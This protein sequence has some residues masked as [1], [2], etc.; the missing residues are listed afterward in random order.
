[1]ISRRCRAST[2]SSASRV[3][4]SCC[5][6][7]TTSGSAQSP[8]NRNRSQARANAYSWRAKVV[9][10]VAKKGSRNGSSSARWLGHWM[11]R[12]AARVSWNEPYPAPLMRSQASALTVASGRATSAVSRAR[13]PRS[14]R[15]RA[16]SRAT[17]SAASG[18]PAALAVMATLQRRSWSTGTP[19]GARSTRSTSRSRAGVP[20]ASDA[21]AAAARSQVRAMSGA[22][23][24]STTSMAR[25][26]NACGLRAA[27]G[28]GDV[29]RQ[30]S[31]GALE[32]GVGD[33]EVRLGG[34]HPGDRLEEVEGRQPA[35][36]DHVPE[37]APQQLP[38]A[39]VRHVAGGP[40]RERRRPLVEQ[41]AGVVEVTH[42]GEHERRH[43][44]AVRIGHGRARALR[45]DREGGHAQVRRHA[46]QEAQAHRVGA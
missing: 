21:A 46:L 13:T 29:V 16:A 28:L 11:P 45:E 9:R 24:R 38:Q 12:M 5:A 18:Y 4:S 8:G 15:S 19:S 43:R 23:A 6:R 39:R 42:V 33:L 35:L 25:S 36:A 37:R 14:D 40:Q 17:R 3:A 34:Q 22:G 27:L 26:T 30:A 10:T 32:H 44:V 41:D 1:M 20:M 31:D 7:A 2:D